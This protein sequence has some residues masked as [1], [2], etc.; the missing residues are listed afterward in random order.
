MVRCMYTFPQMQYFKVPCR[1][2]QKCR[3]CNYRIGG[4]V[5]FKLKI[6]NSTFHI[7]RIQ[8]MLF[9]RVLTIRYSLLLIYISLLPFSHSFIYI[10]CRSVDH[11]E[12][13]VEKDV[14]INSVFRIHLNWIH[15]KY[16]KTLCC[17]V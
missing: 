4:V 17:V 3:K 11:F 2:M 16:C 14:W 7:V 1:R 13:F 6:K 15:M 5:D 8:R 9:F 12:L 10:P